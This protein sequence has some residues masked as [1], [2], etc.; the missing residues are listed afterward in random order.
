[1]NSFKKSIE[2]YDHADLILSGGI[3]LNV[4]SG[5]LIEANVAVRGERILYVG[6]L[7]VSESANAAVMDITGKI[8][9]PGYVEPHCHPWLLYN[10]LSFTEAAA[11]SGTTTF[12]CDNLIAYSLM[13]P[14]RFEQFMHVLSQLPVKILWTCRV[15]PQ[16]PMENEADLFSTENVGR[17]LKSPYT[18]S[19]GEITRWKKAALKDPEISSLIA[20]A[21]KLGKRVDGHTAGA[22]SQWLN[23]IAGAGVESCHE[24]IT[25]DEVLERLRLG[26]YVML[27]ESSLRQDLKDLIREVVKQ[28][29]LTDRLMLTTDAS[30][31]A[32]HQ[33]YGYTDHLLS[34]AMQEGMD[35]VLAYRM[36]TINPAAYFGMEHRIGGIAPGR[37]ADMLV[38]EDLSH[39]TPE[40]VISR[41]KIIFEKKKQIASFPKIDWQQ[42]LP[43]SEFSKAD[44]NAK[45]DDLMIPGN[46]RAIRFPAIRLISTVIT[47]VEWIDFQVS[48]GHLDIRDHPN[49]LYV[50]LINRHGNWVTNGIL[51]GA[52]TDIEGLASSFNTAMQILAIG[53]NPE[54]LSVAVNRVLALRGGIVGIDQGKIAFELELPLGGMMST[55][56][57]GFLAE[58]DAEFQSY[59]SARGYPFH[60][61]LYTL[62]FLP[63]DFLPKVRINFDGVVDIHNEEIL[64]PRR[65]LRAR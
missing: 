60:D 33:Q 41:G 47:R 17:I 37:D 27:R 32:F 53:R 30:T 54:A 14:A 46:E 65:E 58:K 5:E 57:M 20:A 50:S 13:G 18:A 42:F 49:A 44:W 26:F 43:A 61:P 63:N 3:V 25:G 29:V 56:P 31:P 6:Q 7:P 59:M 28:G 40:T 36:V 11:R 62:I 55:A 1:M 51:V 10:P 12:F 9:V 4:Y 52:G 34:T 45:A 38:L 22:R 21:K 16:T 15:V 35:P 48:S 64:W 2:S 19:I 39:P 8:L 23:L 24:S